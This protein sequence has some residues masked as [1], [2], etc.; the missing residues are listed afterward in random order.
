MRPNQKR[1]TNNT[2]K[3][4]TSR[5]GATTY[6]SILFSQIE[7]ETAFAIT[8]SPSLHVHQPYHLPP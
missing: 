4:I 1:I 2:T 8:D 7:Y 3:R 5:N 6:F